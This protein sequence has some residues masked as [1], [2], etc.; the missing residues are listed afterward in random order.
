MSWLTRRLRALVQR[1]ALDKEVE[2]EM[3]LHIDLE[4][5]DLAR[6]QGPPA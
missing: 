1:D 3:R 5:A 6:S 2:D 4:T